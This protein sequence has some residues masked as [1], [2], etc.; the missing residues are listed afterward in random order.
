MYG[1]NHDAFAV[2]PP[3]GVGLYDREVQVRLSVIDP[4]SRLEGG[5]ALIVGERGHRLVAGIRRAGTIWVARHGVHLMLMGIR[6]RDELH[7]VEVD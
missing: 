1:A 5:Q 7:A 6:A 4:Q 2:L 3:R